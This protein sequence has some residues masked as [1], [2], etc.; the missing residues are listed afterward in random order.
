MNSRAISPSPLLASVVRFVNSTSP[1]QKCEQLCEQIAS[2]SLR[3]QIQIYGFLASWIKE[4][5]SKVAS[6][7]HKRIGDAFVLL[8]QL[9]K[10]I[11]P[12]FLME[13]VVNFTWG[14]YQPQWP[15]HQVF[16]RVNARIQKLK[17]FRYPL[18][19]RD[20][21]FPC[22]TSLTEDT[23]KVNPY[24]AYTHELV[25][26]PGYQDVCVKMFK[27]LLMNRAPLD[28][29][30]QVAQHQNI[31]G[32]FTR[33][34][35]ELLSELN[36]LRAATQEQLAAVFS[37]VFLYVH[38]M[39]LSNDID[40]Q[41]FCEYLQSR[42]FLSPFCVLAMVNY[43]PMNLYL[44]NL[45][46]PQ[47]E[48]DAGEAGDEEE[49][50]PPAYM[51]VDGATNT[52][53]SQFI[54]R[55]PSILD[56]YFK[57]ATSGSPE[58][59]ACAKSDDNEFLS[60]LHLSSATV[61][62]RMK[63]VLGVA[64][65]RLLG[66][67]HVS[68]MGILLLRCITL[69]LQRTLT[70]C[71][72]TKMFTP[73]F[74]V[75]V[76][77]VFGSLLP[78][79]A[80]QLGPKFF[81]MMHIK[82]K[83]GELSIRGVICHLVPAILHQVTNDFIMPFCI[84]GSSYPGTGKCA[85]ILL[86][87]LLHCGHPK[88]TPKVYKF[89]TESNDIL[90]LIQYAD[91]LSGFDGTKTCKE[92]KMYAQARE[93]LINRLPFIE[94]KG[95]PFLVFQGVKPVEP[96]DYGEKYAQILNNLMQMDEANCA[97][98]AVK[99]LRAKMDTFV[100]LN[101]LTVMK[102]MKIKEYATVVYNALRSGFGQ[103]TYSEDGECKFEVRPCDM[104]L[105]L[106]Q[107]VLARFVVFGHYEMAAEILNVMDAPLQKDSAPLHWLMK[108]TVRYRKYI[109]M[110]EGKL[111]DMIK[112][113]LSRLQSQAG[114]EEFYVAKDDV[115]QTANILVKQESLLIHDPD[116]VVREYRSPYRH[117]H[118]F[119]VCAEAVT[120]KHNHEIALDLV[121]PMLSFHK[122]WPKRDMACICLARVAA[123]LGDDIGYHYMNVL[124][125][126]AP[127]TMAIKSCHVF[128]SNAGTEL[129]RR[130]A[131]STA[132]L[133]GGDDSR[134]A[135]FL[136]LM[137]PMVQRLEGA[138]EEA[139]SMLCALM[140]GVTEKTPMHIQE[141]I[142]DIVTFT[143]HALALQDHTS[144]ILAASKSLSPNLANVIEIALAAKI[145]DDDILPFC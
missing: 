102:F 70:D 90:V 50:T 71:A 16:E 84:A 53:L 52:T 13:S 103:T 120:S 66:P 15:V 3:D 74:C 106:T 83:L 139:T 64:R 29:F 130:V 140:N 42:P 8:E 86:A 25:T 41:A 123:D 51:M 73:S 79:F 97:K 21:W 135:Y 17:P 101:L 24:F 28:V 43:I 19:L 20:D 111:F 124:L 69:S 125:S 118:A 34:V 72:E 113:I 132:E 129:I 108:F 78:T 49:E 14:I 112:R 44:F 104:T 99:L 38:M 81:D 32:L 7:V 91:A 142:C 54:S 133:I 48:R 10:A 68:A 110:H 109:R 117:A 35:I 23:G 136:D 114:D 96:R 33:A 30:R 57:M 1:S 26:D 116:V 119:A 134:R 63:A 55:M 9:L 141:R 4:T 122:V 6:P 11:P 88:L 126:T 115:F 87:K 31:R 131:S 27:K 76:K 121:M 98:E 128:L 105:I 61:Y 92:T 82:T 46:S 12:V 137:V 67:L 145:Q 5:M 56:N 144:P 94:D 18:F 62:N 143:F 77:T 89:L 65:E 127:C 100:V 75:F 37:S 47:A 85:H 80:E 60:F 39:A 93:E 107:S 138:N 36:G 58:N 59:D 95:Y 40:G 45:L 22:P 2:A